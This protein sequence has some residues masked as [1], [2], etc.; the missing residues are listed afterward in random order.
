MASLLSRNAGLAC[1]VT[2]RSNTR[3]LLEHYLGDRRGLRIGVLDPC[4]PDFLAAARSRECRMTTIPRDPDEWA[5]VDFS[6]LDEVWLANPSPVDGFF[7]PSTFYAKLAQLVAPHK[8]V[9]VLSDESTAIFSFN[10]EPPGSLR[11]LL[12]DER[13]SLSSSLFPLMSP[14]GPET[15]WMLRRSADGRQHC[16]AAGVSQED[17]AKAVGVVLTFLSRQGGA[18]GEF[19]RRMIALQHGM[20][21]L[22][23]QLK[24]GLTQGALEVPNWPET[25]FYLRLRL[26]RLK[27]LNIEENCLD[28][29][30]R[31]GL[32]LVPGTLF[33][34]PRDV[35]VCYAAPHP[36]LTDM[37]AR[38]LRFVL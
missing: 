27:T 35:A 25:G 19:T 5:S 11:Q 20:R 1:Q 34:Q 26:P 30:R 12:G 32:L 33:G 38:I 3:A 31:E 13:V 15:C 22:A 28:L 8:H 10:Q 7:Y 37:A 36:I 6:A 29:A 2:I 17:L 4:A 9:R 16:D 14:Q 18:F 21:L 24:P 23:D